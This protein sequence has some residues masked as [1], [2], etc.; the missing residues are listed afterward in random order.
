MAKL[1]PPSAEARPRTLIVLGAAALAILVTLGVFARNGWFPTTD[2][3]SGKRTGWFGKEVARGSGPGNSWNPLSL[4][5][6]TPTPLPLS[7]ELIYAGSRL[8]ASE[9]A[10]ANAAPP[11][12]LAVWRP[13]SGYWYVINGATSGQ[14]TYQW[15]SSGDTPAP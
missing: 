7:K 10:N 4:P 1:H 8:L 14:S 11:G 12:D 13:G 5:T 9:D 15:G 3:V 2:P 6:P